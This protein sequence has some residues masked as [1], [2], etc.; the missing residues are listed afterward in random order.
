MQNEL[1]PDD[2]KNLWQN[3]SVE[4]VEMSLEQI[5]QKAQMF[6]QRIRNRNLTEYVAA[7]FVFGIFGYYMWRFPEL[8]L[9]SAVILAA[10]V[11]VMYQLHARGAART[12]PESLAL[13]PCL[14][15]HL[16]ELER[17]RNLVRDVWKWYLLPFVPGLILFIAILLR[18]HPEKWIVMLPV[19]LVQT[20][21]FYGIWKLN[22]RAADKLQHQIDELNSMNRESL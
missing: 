8:R 1:P 17:Q 21:L 5:R 14:E 11:Y 7:V 2:L 6:Q 20:A 19:I 16:Q 10:T 3:Q 22:D 13:R 4:P 9:A 12:V 18:H 15:F